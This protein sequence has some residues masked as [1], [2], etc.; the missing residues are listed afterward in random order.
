MFVREAT[1]AD[2]PALLEIYNEAVVNTTASWDHDPWTAV[3]HADW[4]AH[5]AENGFPILVAD[6]DGEVLGYASYS[7]FSGKAGY[8]G[9]REHTVYLRVDARGRGIGRTL[10]EAL[11][12]QAR[13]RGVHTLIGRLSA[14]NEASLRLHAGLGFVEVGRLREVGRKFGRWLDL[15]YLQLILQD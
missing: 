6:Q 8:T 11:I 3:R 4:Y 2:L 15:V 14:D 9:T 10:M 7:E 1:P 12:D 13:V 5:K